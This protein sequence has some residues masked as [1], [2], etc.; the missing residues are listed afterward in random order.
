M[1][2]AVIGVDARE[3]KVNHVL[4]EIVEGCPFGQDHADAGVL[5]I[6]G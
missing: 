6:A 3:N 1:F 2:G 4:C 5:V